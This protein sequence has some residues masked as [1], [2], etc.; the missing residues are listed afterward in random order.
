[1]II[2]IDSQGPRLDEADVFDQF[3]VEPAQ[4]I[5]PDRMLRDSDAGSMRDGVARI[6]IAWLRANRPSHGDDSASWLQR[7]DSMVAYAASRG[8]VLDEGKSLQA[9]VVVA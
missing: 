8:W 9:H 4:G 3:H 7:F 5:D 6:S 1:M 2:R